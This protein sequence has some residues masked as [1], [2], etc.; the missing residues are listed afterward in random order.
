MAEIKSI[1]QLL[2]E[3]ISSVED[4]LKLEDAG[5]LNL[6]AGTAPVITDIERIANIKQSRLYY[7]KDPLAKQAIRLWTD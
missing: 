2:R 5:W 4:Q 7:T 1:E 6:S 3:A